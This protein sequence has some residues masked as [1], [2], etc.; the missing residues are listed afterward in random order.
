MMISNYV[1][2]ALGISHQPRAISIAALFSTAMLFGQQPAIQITLPTGGTT[3]T[4]GQQF[5][6]NVT[7]APGAT[8]NKVLVI[9]QNYAIS[10]ALTN[11]PFAFS[12]TAP[13]LPGLL[14]LTAV[15]A[16]GS[17]NAL[18]GYPLHSGRPNRLWFCRCFS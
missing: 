18:G 7:T 15:G 2:V 8:F 3:V 5:T 4:A 6:V 14:T 10:P 1:S 9:A 17:D 12:F 13:S 16:Q 11:G